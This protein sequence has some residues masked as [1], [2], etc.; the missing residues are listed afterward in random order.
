MR[1]VFDQIIDSG[2]LIAKAG[3]LLII[4]CMIL[5]IV[6]GDSAGT[7]VSTVA[8]NANSFLQ[9][10]PAGTIVG[11]AAVVVAFELLRSSR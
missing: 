8:F 11:L 1:D 3:L 2:W 9:G 4:L 10:L 6:L 7:F 5:K